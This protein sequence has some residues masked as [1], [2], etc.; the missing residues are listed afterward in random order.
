MEPLV[1]HPATWAVLATLMFAVGG[2]GGHAQA[3]AS[4]MLKSQMAPDWASL[5]C[6]TFGFVVLQCPCGGRLHR[7]SAPRRGAAQAG[8]GA[9]PSRGG[10][11]Q[12][13]ESSAWSSPRSNVSRVTRRSFPFASAREPSRTPHRW[14]VS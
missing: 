12:S 9:E 4:T 13:T 11:A 3:L 14:S 6:R 8:V 1:F 5:L 7:R 10:G 2:E